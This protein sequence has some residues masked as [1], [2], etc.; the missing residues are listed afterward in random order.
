[1]VPYPAGGATDV[2]GRFAADA[3]SQATGQRFI[4]E[5]KGG[6]S[7]A[8]GTAEVANAPRRRAPLPGRDARDPC[9]QPVSARQAAL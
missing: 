1:M 5:N 6:A 9:H 7:G 2:M 3:L 8:I 4:V